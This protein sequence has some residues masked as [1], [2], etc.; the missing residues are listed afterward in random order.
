[1]SLLVDMK[2]IFIKTALASKL[3]A[4]FLFLIT[5]PGIA[6]SA[7]KSY[8][9]FQTRQE[10]SETDVL[11]EKQEVKEAT[12]S[13]ELSVDLTSPSPS[14][15]VIPSRVM[16]PNPQ[17]SP[18]LTPKPATNPEQASVS[19]PL[20]Q[21]SKKVPIAIRFLGGSIFYCDESGVNEVSAADAL[22][23]QVQESAQTCVSNVNAVLG[24]CD[25][26]CKSASGCS[27]FQSEYCY[28]DIYY[29]CYN[30]CSNV[31]NVALQECSNKFQAEPYAANLDQKLSQYC[32]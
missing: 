7:I 27:N 3:F 17:P 6:Y 18:Q 25:T 22:L 24:L 31:F 16:T 23:V 30:Q 15:I 28:Q 11:G 19:I 5:I 26:T 4:V 21:Q 32:R 20:L 1:M 2:K 10:R 29:D 14:P 8:E 12:T 9:Y 13:T